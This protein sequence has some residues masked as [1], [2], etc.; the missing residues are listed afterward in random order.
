MKVANYGMTFLNTIGGS[1]PFKAD[2]I[3]VLFELG[4]TQVFDMPGLD[5][6]QF[7]AA[8][9]D[10]HI[11][12]GADGSI[13]IGGGTLGPGCLSNGSNAIACYQNPQAEDPRA[14]PDDFAWGF[15]NVYV[16]RYQDA[17]YGVNLE[18]LIGFFVDVDGIAP[19]PGEN[20]I[21]GRNTYLIGL[22]WDYVNQWA[23][24]VRYTGESGGGINNARLDR[25]TLMMNVRYEF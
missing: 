10:T 7:N 13:G 21:E 17:L 24:E 16:F 12:N 19:G 20:F 4:V 14:F 8:G 25:D 1:N 15:R 9:A 23:G 22:R 5:E 2:Q 3:V 18:P 11:S 6:L